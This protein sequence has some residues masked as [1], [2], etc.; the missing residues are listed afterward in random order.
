M[1][2]VATDG[3]AWSVCSSTYS[4]EPYKNMYVEQLNAV[5][6]ICG[7]HLATITIAVQGLRQWR[8]QDFVTGGSKEVIYSMVKQNRSLACA[9]ISTSTDVVLL[10]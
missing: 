8:R 5:C 10:F 9:R 3:V 4:C 2:T 7:G 1:R 6:E